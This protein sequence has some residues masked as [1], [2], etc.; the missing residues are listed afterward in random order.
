MKAL[1]FNSLLVWIILNAFV[2]IILLAFTV[3]IK[4]FSK[5][6]YDPAKTHSDYIG[7][8]MDKLH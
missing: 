7:R 3:P 1:K 2:F 6:K 8:L 4:V 5:G